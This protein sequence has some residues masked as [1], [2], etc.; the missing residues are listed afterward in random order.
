MPYRLPVYMLGEV[1]KPGEYALNPGADFVDNLVQ[2]GGFTGVADLDKIEV[3]RRIGGR[4]RVYE[5]SW[6]EFQRAPAPQQ[7]DIV[8]VHADKTTKVERKIGLFATVVGVLTSIT[9]ATF[10]VLAYN[11]G[12][13]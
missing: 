9:T 5:F 10:L 2:A 13:I 12:R 6:N 4:K 1:R 3:V 11:R 7:G 8:L